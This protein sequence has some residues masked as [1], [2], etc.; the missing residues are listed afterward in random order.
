MAEG[1]NISAAP[2][3]NSRKACGIRGPSGPSSSG[4]E[5]MTPDAKPM[6][7]SAA[8]LALLFLGGLVTEAYGLHRCP[9]HHGS[10]PTPTA[11]ASLGASDSGPGGGP[12]PC[13]C[14]GSC[15]GGAATPIP[16]MGTEATVPAA[17]VV[18]GASAPAPHPHP[19]YR[20]PYLLPFPNGPPRG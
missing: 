1:R 4:P 12:G 15:H 20:S 2:R 16:G 14:V 10:A 9:H 3:Y 8:L 6:R 5:P 11:T 19:R 17:P 18:S 7:V 13:T